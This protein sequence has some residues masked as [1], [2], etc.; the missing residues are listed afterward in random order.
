MGDRGH[1][2]AIGFGIGPEERIT[3]KE[4]DIQ[5]TLSMISE[6]GGFEPTERAMKVDKLILE[7]MKD[8]ILDID[9]LYRIFY[10]VAEPRDLTN[11]MMKK[12][13]WHDLHAGGNSNEK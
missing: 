10:E 12:K 3:Q 5:F 6:E 4:R 11:A 8:G 9:D 13:K 7:S 1:K 2:G